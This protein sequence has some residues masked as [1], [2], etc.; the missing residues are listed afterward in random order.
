MR[1][2]V[3]VPTFNR[4]RD[5]AR[6]LAALARLDYPQDEFEVIVVDDGGSADLGSVVAASSQRI[7]L[8]L[9]RQTNLGPSAARNNGAAHSAG[10]FLAFV[11]DDCEPSQGW[12]RALDD[13]LMRVPD[14]LIGGRVVNGL[15]SNPND[16]ASQQIL[17]YIS[18]HFNRDSENGGFFPSNNMAVAAQ[19]YRQI[20]GFDA[21]FRRSASEDRDLCDRC[22]RYGLRLI[23]VR[24]A[25]VTHYREMSFCG[26]WNQQFQYGRGAFSY[27][28]ARERRN[29]GPVPFEGWRFHLGLVTSPLRDSLRPRSLYLSCLIL[30]SQVAVVAGYASE[31]R[32]QKQQRVQSSYNLARK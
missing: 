19:L 10:S 28:R 1:F 5:L 17:D 6:C 18:Q 13:T 8:T 7:K 26:F 9:L 3:I 12:L 21:T 23:A 24:E 31:A 15:P 20:G 14:A 22:L 4:P 16:E 27:A 29:G 2:S 25:V 30:V 32:A 11:D